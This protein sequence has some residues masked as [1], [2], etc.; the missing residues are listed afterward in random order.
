MSFD[1][2]TLIGWWQ[3]FG[4]D[5]AAMFS[6]VMIVAGYYVRRRLRARLNPNNSI[7]LV[8][9]QARRFWVE[10][11][12]NTP[13]MEV[14]AVQTLRNFIMVGIMMVSTA[15][16]LI[17]GT[18]TLSGQAESISRTW[19]I[20]NI[21]GSHSAELWIIKVISLL[22]AFLIAFFAAAISVRIATHVLFMVNVPREYYETYELLA[23]VHVARR[24]NQAGHMITI[25]MRA[26]FFAIPL[27]FWLFGPIY[28]LLA[29]IGVIVTFSRLN[30][31]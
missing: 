20:V 15:S 18:L 5:I 24:L 29:T 12:M 22:A 25:A 17:I 7:H 3:E 1:A 8:N 31:F 16:L 21:V 9:Q 2:S 4:A 28:L 23:P 19:H 6:S 10:K 14:M 26:L 27:T 30:R 13:G 11:V